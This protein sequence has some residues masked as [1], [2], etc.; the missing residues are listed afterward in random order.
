MSWNVISVD[1]VSPT[2]WRNGG[3]TSR[4]LVAWPNP[5]DWTWRMSVAEVAKSGPF[6]QFE[7]VQRWFAVVSGAGVALQT[8]GLLHTLGSSSQPICFDGAADTHCAL[9]DGATQ[10]FNLMVRHDTIEAEMSRITAPVDFH[11]SDASVVAVFVMKTNTTIE[12]NGSCVEI[13]SSSLAWR[14]VKGGDQIKIGASSAFLITIAD[15]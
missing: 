11:V 2:A 6:S 5:V 7:G 13:H 14:D 1:A 12:L 10:D 8:G 3:G 15:R 9:I 4:E